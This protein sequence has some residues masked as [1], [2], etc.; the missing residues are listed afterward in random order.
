MRETTFEAHARKLR[1]SDSSVARPI[2]DDRCVLTDGYAIQSANRRHWLAEGRRL[3]GY[4]IALTS[5]EARTALG[6]DEPIYGALFDDM[7]NQSGVTLSLQR[8]ANPMVEA[9]LAFELGCD[10]RGGQFTSAAI[11]SAVAA[12]YPALEVPDRRRFNRRPS[13]IDIV[14]DNAGAA[15][16]VM[17]D[18]KTISLADCLPASTLS[19]RSR[20]NE[21]LCTDA[22]MAFEQALEALAWL[23][24]KKAAE[25]EP[26]LCGQ[27]I[28][29]GSIASRMDIGDG[30][31]FDLSLTGL[32]NV[33]V[34]FATFSVESQHALRHGS[35]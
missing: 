11:R 17:G 14:A 27:I 18:R 34:C 12:V 10:L 26:L 7:R 35:P 20:G 33:S 19:V 16:C 30:D 2:L 8:F 13:L 21:I 6:G 3:A 22:G 5:V 9:E 23:A 29:T 25:D 32:G 15:A 31:D 4:K 28:L 1:S 24:R